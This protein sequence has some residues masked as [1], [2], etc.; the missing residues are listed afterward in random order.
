[1]KKLNKMLAVAS[2]GVMALGAMTPVSVNA[3]S[4][5]VFHKYYMADGG[6]NDMKI[7]GA[8]P[9][10]EAEVVN[11]IVIDEKIA[12]E[13]EEVVVVEVP[14]I[15]EP[16]AEVVEQAVEEDVVINK[17][18]QKY[19]KADGG[20]NDMKIYGASPKK[21]AEVVEPVSP[22][23]PQEDNIIVEVD[24]S[25]EPEEVV[26]NVS[27]DPETVVEVDVSTKE[28]NFVDIPVVDVPVSPEE[29]ESP[30]KDD[31]FITV[32]IDPVEP[33]PEPEAPDKE[34]EDDNLVIKPPMGGLIQGGGKGDEDING[35][36]PKPD[37]PDWEE[38]GKH[39][40]A[41]KD[42]EDTRPILPEN[43]YMVINGIV[44]DNRIEK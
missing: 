2:V 39:P 37:H 36:N 35:A 17:V 22:V 15:E 38:L 11:V 13:P 43:G 12:T 31:D 23:E 20:N 14:V 16:E 24:V 5:K 21:E 33:E 8:S 42:D 19:Y 41:P 4:F 34:D 26:V 32:P 27:P 25:P 1:M 7:Y 28:D 3:A 29:P 18:I 30:D 44:I 6:N 40:I 10:K 9:K